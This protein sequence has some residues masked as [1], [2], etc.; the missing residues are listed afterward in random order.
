MNRVPLIS[1][2]NL[3][4][5]RPIEN[6]PPMKLRFTSLAAVLA[7]SSAWLQAPLT[8]R[9]VSRGAIQHASPKLTVRLMSDSALRSTVVPEEVGTTSALT[10]TG[11][12][13]AE[14]SVVSF[15]RGGLVAVRLN[16]DEVDLPGQSPEV[17]QTTNSLP[18]KPKVL[19]LSKKGFIC[20]V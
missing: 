3:L 8:N 13:I 12:P 14:G 6:I 10:P 16:D 9:A 20:S 11:K 4:F 2:R 1:V 15:F 7:G 5:R 18:D 19:N 17:V